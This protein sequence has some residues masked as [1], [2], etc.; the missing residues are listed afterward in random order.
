MEK[1][2]IQ[3]KLANEGGSLEDLAIIFPGGGIELAMNPTPISLIPITIF[4]R[5]H[6]DKIP[7]YD[8]RPPVEVEDFMIQL[9]G[10]KPEGANSFTAGK[11]FFIKQEGLARGFMNYAIPVC[12][13]NI[14][15][16]QVKRYWA[17]Q[18]E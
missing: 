12:Y 9:A 4:Y 3:L 7:G 11:M 17:E 1:G 8:T 16:E 5:D 18:E 2:P 15:E 6:Q 13:W 10:C 14:N